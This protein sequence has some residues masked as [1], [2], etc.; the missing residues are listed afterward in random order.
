MN[1]ADFV[2][3]DPNLV[4]FIRRVLSVAETGK[5]DWD[6]GATYFYNDGP[7]KRNQATLSI[8]F[9]ASGNLKAVL[10]RYVEKGGSFAAQF[11]PFI[12]VLPGNLLGNNKDFAKLCRQAAT[13]PLFKEKKPVAGGNE[14]VWIKDYLN[15]RKKW[16]A[17][18]SN[19]IL[20][21]TVYRVNCFL[22]ELTRDN[23]NLDKSPIV[24]H[25][26]SVHAA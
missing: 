11:A 15:A 25:G 24:M 6:P 7:N 18:H 5:P 2:P 10:K 14:K 12:S 20:Q 22:S 26:T 21:G 23:W 8:G 17:K 19:K 16:L 1:G 9:T 4:T 13:D 3:F